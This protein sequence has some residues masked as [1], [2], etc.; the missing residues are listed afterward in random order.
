MNNDLRFYNTTTAEMTFDDVFEQLLQFMK[1]DPASL[2]RLAIGTD[3]QVHQ[4]GTK[5]ITSIHL[6][7]VGKGAWGCLKK[8]MTKRRI[9]SLKE[10]ISLET[11]YSQEV[12]ALFTEKHISKMAEILIPYIDNGADF[13][14][15]VHLDIGKKGKTRHLIDEMSEL[16]LAIGLQPK[17]KPNSYA[18]SSYANKY[19]K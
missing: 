5:F 7:R 8:E 16:I 9:K 15:E 11:I 6:H 12:A 14:F 13:S 1:S 17:I 3:S 18:A 2:Y 4:E 10:K 19:T